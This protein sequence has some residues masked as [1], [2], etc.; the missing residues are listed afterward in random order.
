MT[1]EQLLEHSEDCWESRFALP[2]AYTAE[3]LEDLLAASSWTDGDRAL[4]R[5]H[6][7]RIGFTEDQVRASWGR[8]KDTHRTVTA[9]GEIRYLHYGITQVVQLRDGRVDLVSE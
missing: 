3:V 6:R 5:D 1:F 4:I 2:R 8:P 7:I 9:H